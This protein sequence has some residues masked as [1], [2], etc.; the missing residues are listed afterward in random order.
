MCGIVGLLNDQEIAE[1]MLVAMRDV[2]SHRGPDG[3]GNYISKD[4]RVGLG[5]R[6]LSII[7]LSEK[8]RQPMSNEDG[9]VWVTYNGEIYNFETLR[10]E[11]ERHG[12]RFRSKSDTEVIVHAYEEW[13]IDF[14][15]RLNG[16]FVFGLYDEKNDRLMLARDRFGIKPVLYSHKDHFFAFA[17]EIRGLLECPFV[18][19]ALDVT[20][21]YDFLTYQYIP[22]PKTIYNSIRKLPPASYL[23]F[24]KGNITIKPYWDLTFSENKIGAEEAVREV[25]D[26]FREAVVENMISDVPVGLFLSGGIDS[27]AIAVSAKEQKKDLICFCLDF[28]E[29]EK[30]EGL[31]ACRVADSLSMRFLTS[32]LSEEML[33]ENVFHGIVNIFGEPMGD[34]SAFPTY[35]I[36]GVAK[37]HVKVILAG[38]GG[39]EIFAGYGRSYRQWFKLRKW[40]FI[41]TRM[42][43]G[44]NRLS[45]ALPSKTRGL[46]GFIH[47][48]ADPFKQAAHIFGA[49]TGKQKDAILSKSIAQQFK[50]Y[51]DIW[52]QRQFW[53]EDMDP[54][55]RLLYL[56]IKTTLPCRMLVKMDRASMANSLEV[57]VPLLAHELCEF[58]FNLPSSV[59]FNDNQE[60]FLLREAMRGHLSDE[61]VQRPKK[62]FSIPLVHWLEK[63]R[64]LVKEVF[65]SSRGVEMGL[66]NPEIRNIEK[67]SRN[68]RLFGH[69]L[70]S[71]LVLE[72]FLASD[73]FHTS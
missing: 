23:I 54:L 59:I 12:H 6:R 35:V 19:R 4:R 21:L 46:G 33:N 50:D 47:W 10:Q 52:F 38:D 43:R 25:G 63:R 62:G 57:R 24:E 40:D 26:R 61:I 9:T 53:R 1:E 42:T 70:W 41:P 64:D 28:K 66:L 2:M 18:D 65:R 3:Y 36:S 20:A 17:S 51:D 72:H 69:G 56:D 31:Y 49:H 5:H 48:T 37:E 71:A 30:S 29:K 27:S 45:N 7:D 34:H 39:D 14:V 13:G 15:S 32:I 55:H 60:K 58:V 11:L 44:A 73:K 8:G 16:M 22:F 68:Y 67:F